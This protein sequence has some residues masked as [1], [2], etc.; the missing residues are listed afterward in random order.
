M[1]TIPNL[2]GTRLSSFMTKY[3]I[4]AK[5]MAKIFGTTPQTIYRWIN[6]TSQPECLGMANIALTS[7]ENSYSLVS[8]EMADLIRQT[9]QTNQRN[10]ELL[11]N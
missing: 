6:G 3:N 11:N 7:L 1:T 4:D 2:Y 8:G 5:E 9:Q 10:Y